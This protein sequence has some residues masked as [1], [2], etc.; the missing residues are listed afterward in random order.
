[1]S[2]NACFYM[3]IK[4][5]IHPILLP[6]NIDLLISKT[7]DVGLVTTGKFDSIITAAIFDHETQMISLE[8][9]EIMDTMHLN[10]PVSEEF[11]NY[12][13][14]R[15]FLYMIGTDKTHIHEA[16]RIP[17]MHINDVKQDNVGEW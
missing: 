15:T 4:Y 5:A 12:I 1:M 14:Q 3:L 9:G 8:M 2:K 17:L 11:L 6:M 7:Q 10:I 16:Y 13:K